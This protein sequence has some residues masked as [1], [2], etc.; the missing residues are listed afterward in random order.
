ME[1]RQFDLTSFKRANDTMIATNDAAYVQNG[2]SAVRQEYYRVRE[3]TPAEIH[4]II[5]KGTLEEQ[6]KLSRNYFYKDGYYKQIVIY[7]ATLLKYAGLLIPNPAPGKNLSTSHIQK[8]YYSALDYVENMS[9]Q[10]FF[11]NCAQ[12][13]LVDGTYF[14]AKVQ[15][16]S[17]HFSVIDLPCGYCCSR[18]KDQDGNDIVEFDV[19]YFDTILDPEARKAALA[20]YPK[21]VSKAYKEYHSKKPPKK[22]SYWVILPADVGICFPIFDGHPLF[23][24]VIPKILEYDQAV[25]TELQRDL[26][27]IR[28]IIVQ[29]I[30]HLA[31]GHLLF[32]PDEAAEMHSGAVSMLKKNENLSVLTTYADVDAITS[33][34]SAENANNI[35]D[36]VE[37]NIYAQAGVT[38]EVFATQSASAVEKS[39]D[40]DLAFMMYLAGKFSLFTTNLLNDLFANSN[41]S[42]KYTILPVSYYNTQKYV[43]TAFKLGS[44]GYSFLMPAVAMGLSQK[45]LVNIKDLENKVLNLQDR[46][47]PLQSSYTQSGSAKDPSDAEGGRPTKE[48]EDKAET[49][50]VTEE[51]RTNTEGGS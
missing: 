23:L 19:R 28:K 4:R 20:V 38:S 36:R 44:S 16:D 43:D 51:A 31:D 14:G 41:I 18:F 32:E 7:Y 11:I 10:T 21:V 30:P 26:E 12:R 39:L 34:T 1:E 15:V 50:V 5:Q 37:Q 22:L 29:K 25:D 8:R 6:Q 45:D 17:K 46:L 42:F 33:R 9:L 27:E 13:A 48:V 49:T 3:Y 2:W 40:R 47:V 24:S 35:M